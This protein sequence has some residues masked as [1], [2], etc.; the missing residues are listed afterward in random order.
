MWPGERRLA[1]RLQ[2]KLESDYLLWYNV[3]VGHKRQR[4]DF[5][6][7]HPLRGI[8]ILEVKDWSLDNIKEVNPDS[9]TVLTSEGN[10]SFKHPLEQAKSYTLA[11]ANQLQL[12]PLLCQTEARY[13][14]K[15]VCPYSHGAVFPNILRKDLEARYAQEPGLENILPAHLVICQDEMFPSVEPTDFQE[16]LWNLCT[17]QFGKPLT[18][19]QIDRIRYHIFPEIR[20][21]V[22][23]HITET[24]K[25]QSDKAQKPPDLIRVMDL[26]QEQLARSLG[27][28]HR[29]I[30]GVA[31]SGKTMILLYRCR[32]LAENTTKPILVLCYNRTLASYLQAE[33]HNTHQVTICSIHKWC[34]ELIQEYKIPIPHSKKFSNN[35][36]AYCNALVTCVLRRLETGHIPTG[37]YGAVLVDEGHDFKADWYKLV[38]QMVDPITNSLLVLYDDAQSI[39]GETGQ[40]HFSFRS[41]GIQARGRTTILRINYRNT[42][43]ILSLANTFAHNLLCA[44]DNKDEDQPILVQP[45]T[46]GRHGPKPTIIDFPSFDTEVDYLIDQLQELKAQGRNWYE[47]A[48][49][50]RGNFS[51]GDS[52]VAQILVKRMEKAGI[53]VNWISNSQN[54]LPYD[55]TKNSVTLVT[56]HSSKGLEFSAVLLCGLGFMYENEA[57]LAQEVRLLYVAIT[58]ATEQLVITGTSQ[59]VFMNRLKQA[60]E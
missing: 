45:E 23:T 40:K 53:P 6:V 39:Y 52:F 59:S 55:P 30:H 54:N 21:S 42:V 35:K 25:K 38:V 12:D 27:D 13:A 32:Y 44:R 4:P 29:I 34:Y 19:E 15:L 31:G 26:Q 46:A 60:Q 58:R 11:I 36:S 49:I 51:Y 9:W 22:Y 8:I 48:L 20:L 56:M 17:H 1:E 10:K 24:E 2:Q 41:V 50:Y 5:I 7:L 37:Q 28:G 33:L 47:I 16:R 14:G 3:P 18:A 43:E 57:N